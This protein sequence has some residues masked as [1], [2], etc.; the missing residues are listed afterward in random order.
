MD[1]LISSIRNLSTLP[2]QDPP[3]Y[4]PVLRRNPSIPIVN[5]VHMRDFLTL[6]STHIRSLFSL[7]AK[8]S[9]PPKFPTHTKHTQTLSY[10]LNTFSQISSLASCGF[11]R[12]SCAIPQLSI[13][14]RPHFDARSAQIRSIDIPTCRV[15]N[16][17]K[18]RQQEPANVPHMNIKAQA[19]SF[20][21]ASP[22]SENHQSYRE[23][24]VLVSRHG[25]ASLCFQKVSRR[26]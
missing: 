26:T 12:P 3:L 8:Y 9:K 6:I 4:T 11:F 25:P 15:R 21:H 19:G 23:S 24:S 10:I 2:G 13:P 20:K 22:E 5:R 1:F 17:P 7:V 14:R 16:P 18:A